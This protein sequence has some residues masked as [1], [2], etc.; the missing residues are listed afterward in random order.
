MFATPLKL[1]LLEE[2]LQGV[3]AFERPKIKLEQYVTPS[4]I[5]ACM[6]HTIQSRYGDLD[7]RFV[8]DL[9]CGTGMLS[10]G[11]HLLGARAVVGFELDGDAAATFRENVAEME[12][13]GPV[14]CVQCDVLSPDGLERW[15]GA[16]DTVLLNPPFGTKHN[17]G[18]DMRFVEVGL[19]LARGVVYSL[20][21]SSTRAYIQKRAEQLWGVKAEV[22]AELR[23]NLEATYRF[24]KKQSVDIEVDCWRFDVTQVDGG[25]N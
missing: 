14:E 5:A 22:V 8:A 13:P 6:L 3:D 11:A 1:K 10:I 19:R 4:H 25:T 24:H 2:Y 18:Q 21:K 12:L 7:G 16:F 23:Y 9:G 15:A 17:A 20:H